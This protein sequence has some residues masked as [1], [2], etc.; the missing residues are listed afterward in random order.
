MFQPPPGEIFGPP[1]WN[2][3]VGPFGPVFNPPVSNAPLNVTPTLS[4]REEYD[5]NIFRNNQN[6]RADF[7]SALTP[8][9]RVLVQQ[10]GYRVFA[11]YDIS[12]E[13]YARNPDLS[14]VGDRQNFYLDASY[15]WSSRLTLT[16]GDTFV[17][18]YDTSR[19][20][21]QGIATGRAQVTSN[22]IAPGLTYVLTPRDTLRVMGSYTVTRVDEAAQSEARSNSESYGI[23]SILTHTLTPRLNGTIGYQVRRSEF[24]AGDS[25]TVQTVRLGG[26]YQITPLLT[27]LASGGV[28]IETTRQRTEVTPVA[29]VSLTQQFWFGAASVNYN[30]SVGT[31]GTLGQTTDNQSIGGALVAT[32]L[33]PGVNL[34]FA[35]R[36]STTKSST[37]NVKT[38]TAD[39]AASLNINRYLSV[40]GAYTLLLQRSSGSAGGVAGD[41]DQNR[42]FV[43]MQVRYPIDLN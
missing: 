34:M 17:R 13:V 4:I 8:G 41:I 6:R 24:E 7:I 16:L 37:V 31:A 11:G 9:V 19:T 14:N 38:F 42:V 12:A 30:R 3:I 23:D 15:E 1:D 27:V 28:A 32:S 33:L 10:P 26:T 36:Y 25:S 35:P 40:F 20:S 29:T 21:V 43:G 39:L 18:T 22:T 5:D 2:L